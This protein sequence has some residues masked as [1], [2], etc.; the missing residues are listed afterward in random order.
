MG[1]VPIKDIRELI[2]E[3]IEIDRVCYNCKK[4]ERRKGEGYICDECEYLKYLDECCDWDGD[5]RCGCECHDYW[6]SDRY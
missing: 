1:E 5:Y 3:F 4:I 2:V 6:Y